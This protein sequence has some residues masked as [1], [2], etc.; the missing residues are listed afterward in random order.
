MHHGRMTSDSL[1]SHRDQVATAEA[2][3]TRARA[4]LRA[5]AERKGLPTAAIFSETE[6]VPRGT[7]ERWAHDAER[8]GRDGMIDLF[9]AI[10]DPKNSPF[11]HLVGVNLSG[12]ALVVN[13]PPVDV[14]TVEGIVRAGKRTRGEL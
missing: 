13:N 11:A 9:K 1:K 12:P 5:A 14:A 3:L 2:A 10:A 7:A 8:K 4:N 6:F